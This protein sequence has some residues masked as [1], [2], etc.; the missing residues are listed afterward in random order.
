VPLPRLRNKVVPLSRYLHPRVT[1]LRLCR[2]PEQRLKMRREV[3]DR[4]L[5]RRTPRE[6]LIPE[7]TV[8]MQTRRNYRVLTLLFKSET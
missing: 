4:Y 2:Y 1:V 7:F 5:P 6:P 3:S 8:F